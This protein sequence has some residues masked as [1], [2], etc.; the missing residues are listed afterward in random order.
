MVNSAARLVTN[1]LLKQIAANTRTTAIYVRWIALPSILAVMGGIMWISTYL[2]FFIFGLDVGA[3]YLKWVV[4]P[5]TLVVMGGTLW[6][7]VTM[8]CHF[9]GFAGE[10]WSGI[11]NKINKL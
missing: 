5:I 4:F 2:V 6:V 8:L 1:E 9:L 3:I 11:A 7:G 10:A